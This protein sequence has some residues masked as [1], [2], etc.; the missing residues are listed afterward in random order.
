MLGSLST[1]EYADLVAT[2]KKPKAKDGDVRA[3]KAKVEEYDSL[4]DGCEYHWDTE[5]DA[6]DQE[7]SRAFSVLA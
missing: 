3:E 5:L 1:R 2:K 7:K 6:Q 4:D